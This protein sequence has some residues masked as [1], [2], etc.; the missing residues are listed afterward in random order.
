MLKLMKYGLTVYFIFLLLLV[1]CSG[2]NYRQFYI[3]SLDQR[4]LKIGSEDWFKVISD[5]RLSIDRLFIRISKQMDDAHK[6][7]RD[8]TQLAIKQIIRIDYLNIHPEFLNVT[9]VEADNSDILISWWNINKL[10]YYN[11]KYELP[12]CLKSEKK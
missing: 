10:N 8:V 7:D 1:S 4:E 3:D 12:P 6:S 5:N 9:W 11:S 2:N